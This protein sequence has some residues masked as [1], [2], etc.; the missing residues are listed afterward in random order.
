MERHLPY[1]RQGGMGF[2]QFDSGVY[3]YTNSPVA[4]Y[5]GEL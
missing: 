1:L 3:R 2:R 4:N 5:K